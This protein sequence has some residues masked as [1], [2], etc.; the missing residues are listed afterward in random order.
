V[1][2]NP[3]PHFHQY[4]V[5]G[6]LPTTAAYAGVL[7][8]VNGC[9]RE[10]A[11]LYFRQAHRQRSSPSTST[12]RVIAQT[13]ASCLIQATLELGGK[14]LTSFADVMDKGRFLDKAIEAWCFQHFNQGGCTACRHA[15]Q[16]SILTLS[17]SVLQPRRHQMNARWTPTPPGG[18]AGVRGATHQIMSYLEQIQEGRRRC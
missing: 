6:Q 14:S 10:P 18:R 2:S 13:A 16:E 15:D 1:V 5:G 11:S 9:G 7:N 12:D 17:W 4:F 8:I 3:D